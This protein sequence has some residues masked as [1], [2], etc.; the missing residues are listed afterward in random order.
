MLAVDLDSNPPCFDES[1]RMPRPEDILKICGSLVRVDQNPE[2]RNSLGKQAEVQT[3]TAAHASVVDFLKEERVRIGRSRRS[4]I[5][6]P[7]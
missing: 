3:L 2:G 7:L 6:G 4:S 1:N 5:L